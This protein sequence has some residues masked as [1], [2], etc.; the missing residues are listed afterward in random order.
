VPVESPE[1][2]ETNRKGQALLNT[3]IAEQGWTATKIAEDYGRDFDVEVFR[4]HK[5]TGV[6]FSVQLKSS[7]S[8]NYS[9]GGEF[10]SHEL[11]RGHA[12]LFA[13]EM[14]HPILLLIADVVG[15]RLFWAAPQ[16]DL[17]LL[18]ALNLQNGAKSYT[19]RVPVANELPPSKDRMIEA[20]KNIATML[21]V[22]V[23]MNVTM[24]EF[25][26]AIKGQVDPEA[27]SENLRDKSDHLVIQKARDLARVRNFESARTVIGSVISD[28]RA[29]TT[30]KFNALLQS[31]EIEFLAITWG[32]APQELL[33]KVALDTGVALQKL[34]RKGPAAFKLYA[35]IVRLAGEFNVLAIK[36]LGLFMNWRAHSQDGDIL[37][38]TQLVFERFAVTAQLIRKYNQ[39]QRVSHYASASRYRPV[40]LLAL[41][42]IATPVALVLSRYESEGLREAAATLR[43]SAFRLCKFVAAAASELGDDNAAAR[44]AIAAASLSQDPDGECFQWARTELA[45]IQ[46]GEARTFGNTIVEHHADRL[47]GGPLPEDPYQQST[48]KQIYENMASAFGINMADPTNELAK[49]V[50]VGIDDLNVGRVLKNCEHLEIDLKPMSGISSGLRLPTMGVKRL[51]CALH[52]VS[53]VGLALDDLYGVFK[54]KHCD[55]CNDCVPRPAD[56]SCSLADDT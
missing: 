34:T 46:D 51:R 15:R 4:D 14:Q 45:G 40:I 22:R 3:F 54:A 42:R 30:A 36:D 27:L 24:P 9:A 29:S 49:M 7:L 53:V 48:A 37:W 35:L 11:K 50:R 47:R 18:A 28:A 16:V 25:A 38:Q 41:L 31:E 44:S 1:E 39:F 17:T 20:L 56:W 2:H 23:L 33:G 12:L 32:G 52:G 43:A 13:K 26:T 5:T 19:I 6:A 8:P 10:I 21:S 55:N